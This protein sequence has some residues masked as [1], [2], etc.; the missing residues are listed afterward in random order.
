MVKAFIARGLKAEGIDID[1][2]DFEK[3]DLPYRDHQFGT[4]VL[5]AVTEH[6]MKPDHLMRELSRVLKPGGLLIVRTTDWRMDFRN[7]YSDP[8]HVKPY[9][10]EG[11]RTLLSI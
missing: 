4:A 3:N 1:R 2:V 5:N 7:F 6:L 11:M 8:T 10:P 9:V